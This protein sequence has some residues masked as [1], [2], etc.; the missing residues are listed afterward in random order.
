[1]S[2]TENYELTATSF[3]GRRTVR[4]ELSDGIFSARHDFN[5]SLNEIIEVVTELFHETNG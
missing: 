4:A 5:L 3:E 2:E 1:M